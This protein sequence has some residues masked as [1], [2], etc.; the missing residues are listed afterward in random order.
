MQ[1]ATCRFSHRESI[2][3]GTKLT[4]DIGSSSDKWSARA[5][6]WYSSIVQK[7]CHRGGLGITPNSATSISAYY[8]A[9]VHYVSWVLQLPNTAFWAGGQDLTQPASW[10]APNLNALRDTHARL[11]REYQCVEVAPPDVVGDAAAPVPDAAAAPVVTLFLPPLNL[12][13]TMQNSSE[14]EG[15]TTTWP[16]QARLTSHIMRKWAP[17]LQAAAN[18][19]CNRSKQVNEL[20]QLQRI[21]AKVAAPTSILGNDMPDNEDDNAVKAKYIKWAPPAFITCLSSLQHD[22]VMTFPFDWW[23]SW[24]CQFLGIAI[25][26]LNGPHRLCNCGRFVLDALGDH[27]HTCSQHSGSTKDAHEHI[28]SA[29]EKVVKRAGFTTRRKHVTSSRGGQKGDLQIRNIN[30]AGTSD[31]IIDVALVHDYSG[32][33][34]RDVHRNGQLRHA[35]PDTLLNNAADGKVRKYR[36]AYAAPDRLLA[37]L[38]AIM[39]T[40]G[41][42]HGEFLRLLHILSHRQAVNFFELFGEEPTDNAFTFRRAAYFFHNRATIGLACAQATAMRTHVAPHTIRHPRAPPPPHAYDPLLL[43]PAP[44]RAS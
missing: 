38:P 11:L 10:T 18:S 32:D 1:L 33:C 30:L 6:E 13:A 35:D 23:T 19:I 22:T 14:E 24:F 37:F 4:H 44:A 42:I 7:A 5:L 39:S 34:R 28:L 25:P 31:L 29:L 9:S 8:S 3:R 20:H 12:L 43:L 15:N 2:G 36:E 16:T 40:S 26:A 27:S 21:P 41:R 17:H